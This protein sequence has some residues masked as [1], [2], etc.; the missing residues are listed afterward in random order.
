MMHERTNI[1]LAGVVGLLK[2]VGGDGGGVLITT[3]AKP[4]GDAFGSAVAL[5]SALKFLGKA[6]RI[7]VMGPVPA[8]LKGLKGAED[9][10]IFDEGFEIGEPELVVIVDTAAWSQVFEMKGVLSGLEDKMLIID[11]H[12]QGDIQAKHLFIDTGAAACAEIIGEI[13][14]SLGDEKLKTQAIINEALYLGIATD[15][16]WFKFSN[17]TPRTHT[18]AAELLSRGVDHAGMYLVQ[19]NCMRREKLDLMVRGLDSLKYYRDGSVA[20]MVLKR[21]DFS[22][23]GAL[24]EETERLI[25]YPQMVEAVQMVVLISEGLEDGDPVRMSFRS[26]PGEGAINVSDFAGQFGG[27]GHARAAGAKLSDPLDV[28]VQKI[29]AAV[30]GI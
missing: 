19:E 27:G 10:E 6:V 29:V 30:E 24:M 16:G 4:D 9:L 26:K 28:V 13:V 25:D 8:S 18:W 20:M 12:L 21:S 15:T 7:V 11:H 3:H 23:T 14:D 22:E 1:D 5:G 17:T 2:G